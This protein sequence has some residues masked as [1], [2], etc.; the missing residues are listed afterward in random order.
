MVDL[1]CEH[2]AKRYRRRRTV[3]DGGALRFLRAAGW[4]EFWA[5]RD[6]SF[7]VARGEA[8]GIIGHNG[9]GK[10]TILKLLS[11]I[12]APSDGQISIHG[13]LSALIEVGS[14]FHPELTGRENVY[15]NG[16]ILGMR[17][18]EITAKL[19]QIVEFA[20]VRPFIDTPVKWY[21]SGMYVRLGFAIAAHLEPDILLLDE[22]LA[23]G[24]AEFQA[25]C[26]DRIAEL[27][28]A[29]TTMIYISHDTGAVERLCDRVLLLERGRV[30]SEGAPR[31]IVAR[32][33]AAVARG[34]PGGTDPR[35]GDGQRGRITAITLETNGRRTGRTGE[36]L[37][38]SV[39]Y[40]ASEPI[41]DAVFELRWYSPAHELESVWTTAGVE[42]LRLEPGTG[43]V[44]FTCEA[45]AL[46][47]GL[48]T[49]E[50]DLRDRAM[51]GAPVLH[52]HTDGSTIEVEGAADRG[53]V[54]MP[55]TFR[56][57]PDG[58]RGG[59]LAPRR[60]TL[61]MAQS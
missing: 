41:A 16:A 33:R 31:D 7:E 40:V 30:V 52:S 39:D 51:A 50:G 26:L 43:S 46:G 56:V 55:H 13:R 24:D 53:R 61:R 22:V 29:G 28:R 57:R 17:R 8:V 1:R 45:L 34:A 2:I 44:E 5:V 27:K 12:T 6:V 23:V 47:P 37:A 4:E 58:G 19:E 9:A 20:G 25:R 54:Y 18:R 35:A 60:Q 49:L 38:L 10:S 59:E 42:G 3:R 14:G 11:R 15:L 21:S 48:Y 32:Y 36:A